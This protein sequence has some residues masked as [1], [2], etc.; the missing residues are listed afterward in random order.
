[1]TVSGA[2]NAILVAANCGGGRRKSAGLAAGLM[3]KKPPFI[4]MPKQAGGRQRRRGWHRIWWPAPP[5]N[6]CT[7]C[8]QRCY[9]PWPRRS[10]LGGVGSRGGTRQEKGIF[11]RKFYDI[12]LE[13]LVKPKAK[14]EPLKTNATTNFRVANLL[15]FGG[16]VCRFRCQKILQQLLNCGNIITDLKRGSDHSVVAPWCFSLHSYVASFLV[17][18]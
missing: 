12:S 1:M 8:A 15:V 14:A 18:T 16:P 10:N 11:R 17:V 6:W 5:H 4:L 3:V 13:S 7:G 9:S 2:K